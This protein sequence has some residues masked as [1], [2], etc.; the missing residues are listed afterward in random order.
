MEFSCIQASTLYLLAVK[1]NGQLKHEKGKTIEKWRRKT[2]GAN[3]VL[4]LCQ[5][6]AGI[7]YM[8]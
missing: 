1:M 8:S 7:V 4:P 3:T 5:P 2:T 6:A